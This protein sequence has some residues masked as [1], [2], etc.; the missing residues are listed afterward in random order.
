MAS[1]GVKRKRSAYDAGFKLKVVEYA[2]S[3]NSS[4]AGHEFGVSE[5]LVR[6]WRKSKETVMDMP[7]TKRGKQAAYPELEKDLLQWI[8]TQRKNGYIVTPFVVRIHAKKLAREQGLSE[9]FKE[10]AG[11]C[12]R[13]LRRFNL[14]IH[15]RTKISQ[16]LSNDLEDKI[17]SF[18][19]Y[20]VKLWRQHQF[21]ISQIGNM[22][23]THV[24]FCVLI[25][26]EDALLMR[27]EKRLFMLGLQA[28]RGL[29]SQL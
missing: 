24:V 2:E 15:Q 14:S 28:K 5:K 19:S 18:H 20:V 6:D 16:K 10:S 7:K 27:L 17:T 11:W 26:L 25:C 8:S 13:F 4:K 23:E 12:V 3:N 22:D 21:D 1:V 9:S 29:T